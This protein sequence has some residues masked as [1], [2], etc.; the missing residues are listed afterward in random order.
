[1]HEVCMFFWACMGFPC[2]PK[3][4]WQVNWLLS[5]VGSSL[6]MYACQKGVKVLGSSRAGTGVNVQYVGAIYIPVINN[7]VAKKN[8]LNVSQCF[9]EFGERFLA[10][11]HTH[12]QKCVENGLLNQAPV[13]G[14]WGKIHRG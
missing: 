14:V 9:N 13:P 1:M 3:T 12:H 8:Y 10:T 2:T 7:S 4:C 11:V 6:C 5:K